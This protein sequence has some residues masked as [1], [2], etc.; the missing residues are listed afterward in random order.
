MKVVLAQ[1]L[2]PIVKIHWSFLSNKTPVYKDS[3]VLIAKAKVS[4]SDL[5]KRRKAV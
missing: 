5:E 2:A 4:T 3:L 1:F